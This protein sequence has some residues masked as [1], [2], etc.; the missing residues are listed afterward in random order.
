MKDT[1]EFYEEAIRF[2][3]AGTDLPTFI[4]YTY[5]YFSIPIIVVDEGYKL[6]AYDNGGHAF[7]DPYWEAIVDQ[8][9]ASSQTITDKYM[10]SGYIDA[11]AG[12]KEAVYVNWGV[13][14]A[15]PQTCGA[16]VVNKQLEGYIGLLFMYESQKEE[17]IAL[18]TMLCRLCEILMQTSEYRKKTMRDPVRQ[19]FA[20][21]FFDPESAHET[22]NV[23]SY[24]PYVNLTP[25]F[26]VAVIGP[27]GDDS[28]KEFIRGRIRSYYPHM[29]YRHADDKLYILLDE[30][31]EDYLS[32]MHRDLNRFLS[33]YHLHVGVSE[34]FAD[35]DA[36]TRYIEQAE[37]ALSAGTL[38]SPEKA[39]YTYKDYY[40][41]I[42]LMGAPSHLQ[43]DNLIPN[44]LQIL[45]AYDR[46]N[47]T[48]YLDSLQAY[49][50]LRNDINEA[51]KSMHIHR[52]T[53][54][55]RLDKIEQILGIDCN[56]PA[57]ARHLDFGFVMR[58]LL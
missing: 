56:D 4:H 7:A 26:C 43:A 16:I 30:I 39:L 40:E 38:V 29:I 46:E 54:K 53:M 28:V 12:K 22:L 48:E 49:L 5:R 24:T 17:V 23:G 32:G 44:A 18:N 51:A 15:Y 47:E 57:T 21:K 31:N 3:A 25:N 50:Y 10:K 20:R 19:V 58:S 45:E 11:I 42:L 2:I 1:H 8:G 52:N 27:L 37:K 36:R 55:Y 9:T 34:Y 6:L 33:D 41:A 35:L 14:K 13:S